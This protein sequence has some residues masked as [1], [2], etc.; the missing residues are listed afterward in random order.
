MGQQMGKEAEPPLICSTENLES[1]H[2][3]RPEEEGERETEKQEIFRNTVRLAK[4][5]G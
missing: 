3:Q 4:M 2:T 1:G 5:D